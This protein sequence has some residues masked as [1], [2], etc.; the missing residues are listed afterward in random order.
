M[1]PYPG[2]GWRILIVASWMGLS[3]SA[4][5]QEKVY[6]P[7]SIGQHIDANGVQVEPLTDVE[8]IFF[9]DKDNRGKINAE[10][11]KELT[12]AR[13][14]WME[15]EREDY[16]TRMFAPDPLFNV[17]V[18]V[19]IDVVVREFSKRS[20]RINIAFTIGHS[21]WHHY[22]ILL[23]DY[24]VD[25]N[26]T[27]DQIFGLKQ[28]EELYSAS[29]KNIG[30]GSS[31]TD[32][33]RALGLNYTEYNGQ[34]PQ[35]RTLWFADHNLEVIIQDGVVMYL[36][37]GKPSWVDEPQP[38]IRSTGNEEVPDM[39]FPEATFDITYI[40]DLG[41]A[42]VDKKRNF[43]FEIYPFDNG[44]DYPSE[45]LFRIRENGK[46]GYADLQGDIVI[47]PSFEFANP[48]QNGIAV[49]SEEGTLEQ[50]GEH[51]VMKAAKWGVIDKTGKIIVK[52]FDLGMFTFDIVNL[53]L[54]LYENFGREIEAVTRWGKLDEINIFISGE[55]EGLFV[56]LTDSQTKKLLLTYL[57]LPWQDLTFRTIS[58]SESMI[59][60][61]QL[62]TVTPKTILYLVDMAPM[63]SEGDMELLPDLSD[64]MHQ[65]VEYAECQR[66]VREKDGVTSPGGLQVIQLK[67]FPNYMEVSVATPGSAFQSIDSIRM[68]FPRKMILLHQVPDIGTVKSSWI[69]P[70]PPEDYPFRQEYVTDA[71][72][73]TAPDESFNSDELFPDYEPKLTPDTMLDYMPSLQPEME[74]IPEPN[75]SNLSNLIHLYN[76]YNALASKSPGKWV[77]GNLVLGA[78]EKEYQPS[79]EELVL[80]EVGERIGTVVSEN[81]HESL[82]NYLTQ[83]D[84]YP[85]KIEFTRFFFIHIDV[86][87]SGRFFYID[88]MEP[89]SFKLQ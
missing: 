66:V 37:K 62:V 68:E 89:V 43:L 47:A 56:D 7:V 53:K 61:E 9:L 13:D 75:L 24:Q 29:Y 73:E 6:R 45:G 50:D 40:P 81:D 79:A 31:F 28:L 63:L 16:L 15:Q 44:P 52:P 39:T 34:S 60:T 65:L 77:D 3:V 72:P 26:K 21:R 41:F 46:I 51:S 54:M 19:P 42:A 8:E 59:P 70:G 74:T 32:V 80:M 88:A 35:Y 30:H 10:T 82:S 87:G 17:D 27:V 85:E 55:G 83:L 64:M 18:D 14:H 12:T 67:E 86:M 84:R 25:R 4:M 1:K 49:I 78:R 11:L 38:G 48:F 69:K 23:K 76:K 5:S 57:F 71:E 2:I 22:H 20:V 36:Q 58:E 33:L